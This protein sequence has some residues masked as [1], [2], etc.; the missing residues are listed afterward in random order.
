MKKSLIALAMTT[1]CLGISEFGMMGI[2][3]N[4]ADSLQISIVTAG[5]LI[6][7]YSLGVAIGAPGLILLRRWPMKRL[8]LMLVLLLFLALLHYPFYLCFLP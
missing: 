8:L 3:E 7:A 2:L 4:V 5:H 6:S 1:F